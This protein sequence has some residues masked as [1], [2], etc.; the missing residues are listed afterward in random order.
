MK[1]TILILAMLLQGVCSASAQ[2]ADLN[3]Y[4]AGTNKLSQIFNNFVTKYVDSTGGPNVPYEGTSQYY[5]A[6]NSTGES[7]G[8]QIY[9]RLDNYTAGQEIDISQYSHLVI[10][11]K[12]TANINYNTLSIGFEDKDDN[13]TDFKEVAESSDITTYQLKTIALSSFDYTNDVDPDVD[14]T[15]IVAIKFVMCCSDAVGSWFIDNIY[16]TNNPTTSVSKE[17]S[18][19]AATVNPNPSTGIYTIN[20]NEKIDAIT[21]SDCL[22][23]IV[24]KQEVN[25]LPVIDLTAHNDGVYFVTMTSGDKVS[26]KRVI[27][28]K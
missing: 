5:I 16:L 20:T 1:K 27:K 6:Y 12:G 11:T 18:S 19:I 9:F 21:V 13:P 25:G 3:I 28:N 22:G 10:A 2:V 7:W 23:N 8:G 15:K 17:T 14:K 4:K 24:L 26:T